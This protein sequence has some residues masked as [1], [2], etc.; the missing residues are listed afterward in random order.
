MTL[1]CAGALRLNL[2]ASKIKDDFI[3]LGKALAMHKDNADWVKCCIMM[4]IDGR[5]TSEED[6]VG[7]R[8]C[9]LHQGGYVFDS[10]GWF[11]C[12]QD[13]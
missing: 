8:T 13:Y 1:L 4:E 12:Q 7:C 5:V 10:V 6:L 3:A 9:Y 2:D 11:V